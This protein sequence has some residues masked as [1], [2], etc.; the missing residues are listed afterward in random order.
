MANST[1]P[2]PESWVLD[3]IDG[4]SNF[5][6]GLPL[7][8]V[9]LALVERGESVIGVI[10]APF[11]GLRYHATKGGGAF[12]NEHPIQASSND[13]PGHA[14]IAIGDYAVG[15]GADGKNDYRRS[16]TR[17]FVENVERVRM[18]GSA[19]L[20]LVLVTEGRFD[21]CVL[22]WNKPWD[23]AAG[24]LIAREAGAIVADTAGV[25]HGFSSSTTVAVAPRIAAALWPL[26]ASPVST[27]D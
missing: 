4:T 20:D 9:S 6:H 10:A 13:D 8:A 25:P 12:V 18:I 27:V 19:A 2:P 5:A 26:L 3:P 14:I 11:L 1:R 16:V 24:V 21:A 23:T 22:Y 15:P 7:C 17:S